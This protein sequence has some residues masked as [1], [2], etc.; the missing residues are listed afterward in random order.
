MQLSEKQLAHF[1]NSGY[2]AIEGFFDPVEAEALRLELER[3]YDT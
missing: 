2:L 1:R 3:I